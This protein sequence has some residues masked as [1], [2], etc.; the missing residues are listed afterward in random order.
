[1]AWFFVPAHDIEYRPPYAGGAIQSVA[2]SSVT[3][4]ADEAMTALAV[5]A[6]EAEGTPY[7][8][9]VVEVDSTSRVPAL[10]VE[11]A[12]VYYEQPEGSEV[13]Y[14][15]YAA[16]DPTD[17]AAALAAESAARITGDAATLA[18]AATDA[19]TKANAAQAAAAT[20]ATAKVAT[21][22]AARIAADT[23][24]ATA[25]SDADALLIPLAQKGAAGGVA[26]LDAGS[27]VPDAQIPATIARDTEVAA[28]YAPLAEAF[29]DLDRSA[30]YRDSVFGGATYDRAVVAL[31]FDDGPAA[32][33][34]TVYPLLTARALPAM[35]ALV[36][37]FLDQAGKLTTAQALEMQTRGMEMASHSATHSA[38]PAN[39][40]AF[41]AEAITT[42][43]T[44]EA[45]GLRVDSFVQP[46]PWVSGYLFDTEA[47]FE[48]PEGRAL[49][50]TYAA[51]EAYLTDD[52][53]NSQ[54]PL[55]AA[56]RYGVN[57]RTAS[58]LSL[59]SCTGA[60][61]NA[62]IYG[63]MVEFVC[64]ASDLDTGGHMSLADF[65]TLLDYIVTKRDAAQIDVLTPTGALYARK[66]LSKVNLF[67]DP[68]FALSTT[69]APV[70][71]RK[72]GS[73]T[74]EVAV[75][76]G[77][78]NAAKTSDTNYWLQSFNAVALRTITVEAMIANSNVTG[79][80]LAGIQFIGSAGAT[81]YQDVTVTKSVT[82]AAG[83]VKFRATFRPHPLA[84]AVTVAIKRGDNVA[85]QPLWDN[86]LLYKS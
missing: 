23:A 46:G 47:D 59:A 32:D 34:T 64:H 8:G 79:T 22:T 62:I 73:P 20:D 77:G 55:P 71:W 5:V 54:K 44:L 36:T 50:R 86:C 84:T 37:S 42:K 19:T 10:W 65:T 2:G 11:D 31:R 67:G 76:V 49:R 25:R 21:E 16:L 83:F 18:S 53:V 82:T 81:V 51:V 61:D 56:R 58:D 48:T 26:T 29:P 33:Y 69:A 63:G 35:F 13:A 27:A 6:A 66:S 85:W 75:G 78:S 60:I 40:A 7:A 3:A 1:M 72:A 12:D 15:V 41:I 9:S 45:A 28:A 57:H 4:W 80:A 39:L 30:L 17:Q 14:P 74:I 38:D 43:A 70:F 24:E 52:Y 68:D